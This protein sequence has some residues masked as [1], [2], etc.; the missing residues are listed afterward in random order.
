MR[1]LTQLLISS[2]GALALVCGFAVMKLSDHAISPATGKVPT[3]FPKIGIHQQFSISCRAALDREFVV[4]INLDEKVAHFKDGPRVSL[5]EVFLEQDSMVVTGRSPSLEFV[6][7]LG[8][9]P[10]ITISDAGSQPRT[11]PCYDVQVIPRK[12]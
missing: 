3:L 12:N 6:A 8:S 9:K 5:D 10:S 7:T 2:G 11:K 1:Q 4:N